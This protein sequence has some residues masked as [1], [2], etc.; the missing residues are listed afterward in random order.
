MLDSIL[1]PTLKFI[2][3]HPTFL[4]KLPG[5]VIQ[6]VVDHGLKTGL[7]DSALSWCMS[8]KSHPVAPPFADPRAS[9]WQTWAKK[10]WRRMHWLSTSCCNTNPL[11]IHQDLWM[12]RI[13][14]WNKIVVPNNCSTTQPTKKWSGSIMQNLP[15]IE[16]SNVTRFS[17]TA[18]QKWQKCLFLSKLFLLQSDVSGFTKYTNQGKGYQNH[19]GS[20]L[21]I[22]QT[23]V[24]CEL[25]RIVCI[26]FQLCH[27]VMVDVI[28]RVVNRLLH[29]P[30]R[31]FGELLKPHGCP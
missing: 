25:N 1:A 28:G 17:A 24:H 10:N 6:E 20:S 5:G 27:T 16:P 11:R 4:H 31:I 26:L 23:M 12:K 3:L 18:W 14:V 29:A 8:S 30:V 9:S 13:W 7:E 19:F 22:C 15:I 2:N 21:A